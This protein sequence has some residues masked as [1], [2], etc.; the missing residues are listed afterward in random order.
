MYGS[1][2]QDPQQDFES[3]QSGAT[4]NRMNPH[5]VMKEISNLTVD[6]NKISTESRDMMMSRLNISHG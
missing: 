3:G 2:E 1:T 4:T 6:V 5:Q